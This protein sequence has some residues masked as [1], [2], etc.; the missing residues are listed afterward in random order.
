MPRLSPFELKGLSAEDALAALPGLR[1]RL[2]LGDFDA[3]AELVRSLAPRTLR[4]EALE[5][6]WHMLAEAALEDEI[7]KELLDSA[8]RRYFGQ[9]GLIA[10]TTSAIVSNTI[11]TR[12]R[13]LRDP[14][15]AERTL[16]GVAIGT[17]WVQQRER[18]S[19]QAAREGRGRSAEVACERCARILDHDSTRV[20]DGIESLEFPTLNDQER[21][22]LLALGIKGLKAQLAKEPLREENV[23]AIGQLL[24]PPRRAVMQV[25]RARAARE[26]HERGRDWLLAHWLQGHHVRESVE[27]I[28]GVD[29]LLPSLELLEESLKTTG[30]VHLWSSADPCDPLSGLLAPVALACWPE[31]VPEIVRRSR[32]LRYAPLALLNLDRVATAAG[33]I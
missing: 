14:E 7:S 21:A 15:D 16:C 2:G 17:R 1:L 4:Q 10:K 27:R 20:P 8:A 33:L 26:A 13:H 28:Y 31:A 32:R 22:Q 29:A 19:F 5:P 24:Y 12:L 6:L 18:G 23:N 9:L 25:F 11:A 3:A 30:E